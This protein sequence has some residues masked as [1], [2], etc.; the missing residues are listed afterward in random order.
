MANSRLCSIP[1]CGKKAKTKSLCTIHYRRLWQY[2]D[3]LAGRTPNGVPLAFL[4]EVLTGPAISACI[5][6][7]YSHDRRGYGHL[8]LNGRMTRA[9]RII[10]EKVYGKPPQPTCHAAH[11]C[12]NSTCVNPRHLQWATAKENNTHKIIHGTIARGER[13]GLSKLTARDVLEIRE[14]LSNGAEANEICRQFGIG[15]SQVQRI[16]KRESWAWL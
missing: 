10:C 7:P 8:R 5:K 16:K 6:W 3:P 2:G 1:D 11:L 4:E 9:T 12:G 14:R 15:R 13:Q